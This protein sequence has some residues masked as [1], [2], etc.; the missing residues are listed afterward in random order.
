MENVNRILT[1][2]EL[3]KLVQSNNFV[4]WVYRIDYDTAWIMTNDL[5][6]VG[7][8]TRPPFPL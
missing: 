1:T 6:K 2:D 8:L 7:V 5:W 3:V 4:G